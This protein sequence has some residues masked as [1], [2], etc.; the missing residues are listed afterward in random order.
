MARLLRDAGASV[1]LTYSPGQDQC[2]PLVTDAVAGG[3][4]VVAVGGDGMLASVAGAVMR[5]HGTLGIVPAGRGNDFARQLG[6]AREPESVATTLLETPSRPID[7]IEVGDT[8]V[9]GSVYAGIDSLSSELVNAAHWLPQTLQYPYAA[10]RA[11]LT[12]KP[13]TYTLVIDGVER[14][15]AAYTVVV[16]NSGYYGSGMQIAPGALPDDGLLSIVI[17]GA[18]PRLRL[19]RAMPKIYDGSHIGQDGVSVTAGRE[20]SIS[21]RR[22]LIAY[23]D[24]ERIGSLPA[25]IRVLPGAL[26]VVCPSHAGA[27]VRT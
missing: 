3:E 21:S 1:A 20:I 4:V 8:I 17:I 24:G 25:S 10:I 2:A 6:L 12:H 15:T 26:N 14:I 18:M 19:L 5:A 27:G 16:A 11:V 22:P 9:V 7:V 23:G 13:T